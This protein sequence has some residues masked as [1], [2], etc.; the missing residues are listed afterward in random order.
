LALLVRHELDG[1]AGAQGAR[2]RRVDYRSRL[3]QWGRA[4]LVKLVDAALLPDGGR[5]LHLLA[6][7][8]EGAR[9]AA[10]TAVVGFVAAL[11]EHPGASPTARGHLLRGVLFSALADQLLAR[12]IAGDGKADSKTAV[13]LAQAARAE[14]AAAEQIAPRAAASGGSTEPAWMARLRVAAEQARQAEPD[15]FDD[16]DPALDGQDDGSTAPAGQ[17]GPKP[18]PN[19]S[20]QAATHAA[21]AGAFTGPLGGFS[22]RTPSGGQH[23]AR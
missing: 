8:P 15:D 11:A 20:G 12:A 6:A 4:D 3:R 16:P 18:S 7:A 1:A 19:A 5:F 2:R 23:G 17:G 22:G 9:D 10:A 13:V 14:L 21:R